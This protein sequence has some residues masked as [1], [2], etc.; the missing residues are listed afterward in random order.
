MDKE[1][2]L[3]RQK[4]FLIQAA[5]WTV[6][7]AVI[8]WLLK[9]VGVA[10]LPF[11]TAFVVA[12]ALSFVVDAAVKY[13]HIGRKM[14]AVL[15]VLLFYGILF[16]LFYLLGWHLVELLRESASQLTCFFKE[17]VVSFFH[18][19][20]AW[21][22]EILG[23]S[24]QELDPMAFGRSGNIVSELS[25]K[26]IDGVSKAAVYIPGICMK[27]FLTILSTM[28][29][30]LEFSEICA[31]IK[32]QIPPQW[33]NNVAEL[34]KYMM[35]TLGRC[36]LSYCLIMALTFAEL[37]VGFLLL[38]IEG[39]VMLAFVIALLDIF[40]VFGT[41]TI[42]LPWAVM[43]SA[44]G[45]LS[46]GIGLLLLYLVITVVRNIVEPHLVGRQMGL[47]PFV[48]LMSMMIGLHFLGIAGM[49]LLPLGIAFVKSLNDNGVIHIFRTE[50]RED[51][52]K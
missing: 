14:A 31:F 26:L 44:N 29:I 47:S 6:L 20:S 51:Y 10:V 25:G 8:V 34:K 5:Y 1:K 46:L 15:I 37:T 7:G 12:W 3:R 35:G 27:L 19:A 50:E 48:T 4:R 40:P 13:L 21:G 49:F 2:Q 9:Y 43:V 36:V 30:E 32:R 11:L 41:G 24:A 22:E 33:E 52:K 28:L 16:L 39:A 42:L 38:K 17:S 45:N 18:T 23:I